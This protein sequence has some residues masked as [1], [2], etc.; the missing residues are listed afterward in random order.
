MAYIGRKKLEQVERL[1]VYFQIL[2]DINRL[3]II[4][5]INNA[6]RSVS[7][8]VKETNMSQPLVSHHLKT[9]KESHIL[10]TRRT[11]PFIY[12]KLKNPKLLDVLGLFEEIL[13]IEN[14]R[15]SF[16]PMFNC[17]NWWNMF[18]N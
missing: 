7:E 3:R 18:N 8:I 5:F 1:Q 4:K 6:E 11:G 2:S 12:Y 10:E 17:P 14:T 15:A 13:P 16:S 9:L